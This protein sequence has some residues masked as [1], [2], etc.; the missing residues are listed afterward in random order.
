MEGSDTVGIM[1]AWQA[2]S[3]KEA[4][5][6]VMQGELRSGRSGAGGGRGKTWTGQAW[7]C[8]HGMIG[9]VSLEREARHGLISISI[10]HLLFFLWLK[11][12]T[13]TK[14]QLL[15]EEELKLKMLAKS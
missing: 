10:I 2:R 14:K 15:S 1:K 11:K 4:R 9:M 13:S 12:I 3:V 6:K 5:R 8:R 7:K